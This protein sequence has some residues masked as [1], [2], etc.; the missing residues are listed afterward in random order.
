[1][2][3][4]CT[5]RE[6]ERASHPN[7]NPNPNPNLNQVTELIISELLYLQNDSTEK[8]VLQ[9]GQRVATAHATTRQPPHAAIA[10]RANAPARSE[11]TP[12]QGPS[13]AAAP[14]RG[15]GPV[16][17]WAARHSQGEGRAGPLGAPPLPRVLELVASDVADST[18]SVHTA[19]GPSPPP[20]PSPSPHPSITT[21]LSA[22]TPLLSP[23]RSSCTSTRRARRPRLAR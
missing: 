14:P 15:T 8:P 22:F 2:N 7:P 18:A 4:W 1:M 3:L 20:H 17:L 9:H 6:V 16:G 21:P 11:C 12:R 5:D 13:S 23:R 19:R 10:P